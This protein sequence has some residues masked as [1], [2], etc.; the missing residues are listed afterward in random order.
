MLRE[1]SL[2]GLGIGMT[3][4]DFQIDG[5]RQ[6]VTESLKSAV[7]YSIPL[8]PRCFRWKMLSLSGPK[9]RVLLQLLI[10]L[11]TWSV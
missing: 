10:P 1:Q 5:I 4:D 7:R 3:M 2:P 11:V 9:A 8:D 6:D